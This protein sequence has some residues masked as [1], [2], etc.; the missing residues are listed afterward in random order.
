[1]TETSKENGLRLDEELSAVM[2]EAFCSCFSDLD[3]VDRI[4][5]VASGSPEFGDYQCN[6]AMAL[7]KTLSM[8]PRDIAAKVVESMSEHPGIERLEVAGPG[9]INIHLAPAWLAERVT[10]I[11]GD[12]RLCVLKN[13]RWAGRFLLGRVERLKEDSLRAL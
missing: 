13:S 12:E 3:S 6:A 9:F 1:M 2:Q 8:P 5:A 7:K 11:A 10:A 4:R